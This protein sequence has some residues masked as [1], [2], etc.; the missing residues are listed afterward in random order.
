MIAGLLRLP[1]GRRSAPPADA[2][3]ETSP[4]LA[5]RSVPANDDE[6]L[7]AQGE[8]W[9]NALPEHARPQ[10]LASRH[11]RVINRLAE[12]W[13]DPPAA[14]QGLDRLLI[15]DRGDRCGFSPAIRAELVRLQY[16]QRKLDIE[17]L[18][19]AGVTGPQPLPSVA[20]ATAPQPARQSTDA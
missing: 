10:R 5:L 19:T 1:G 15:D 20:R 13:A 18:Q 4:W 7:N 2:P 12:V 3:A 14:A 16:L 6:P 11:P 8:A 17:P 9:L